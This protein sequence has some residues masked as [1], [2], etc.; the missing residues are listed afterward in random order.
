MRGRSTPI[1]S[2]VRGWSWDGHHPNSRGLYTYHSRGL[3]TH[4]KK[5]Q[6]CP[7][8]TQLSNFLGTPGE[9]YFKGNPKSLNFYF[10]VIWWGKQIKQENHVP[11]PPSSWVPA[12]HLP[13]GCP[14]FFGWDDP[15]LISGWGCNHTCCAEERCEFWNQRKRPVMGRFSG[16]KGADFHRRKT[17]QIT[18]RYKL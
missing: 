1:C 18:A 5:Y 6:T 12:V 16:C 4:P 7:T 8:K 11:K 15:I 9:D 3:Y 14:S 13:L 17:L 10:L 2:C